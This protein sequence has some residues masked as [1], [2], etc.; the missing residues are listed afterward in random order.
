MRMD[1]NTIWEGPEDAGGPTV[2]WDDPGDPKG[3]VQHIF[4]KHRITQDDVEDVLLNPMND[5]AE[6][7]SSGRYITFGSTRGGRYIAV[8]WDEVSEYPW[9]MR[10]VTAYDVPRRGRGR[11]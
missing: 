2:V 7:E 1:S 5:S 11:R 4:T 8:V 3:N 10:P 9:E 6:A